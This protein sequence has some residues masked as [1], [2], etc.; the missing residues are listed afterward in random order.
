MLNLVPGLGQNFDLKGIVVN[1][2]KAINTCMR[3]L[4]LLLK[5][6]EDC[7]S[8]RVYNFCHVRN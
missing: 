6:H 5:V 1:D 2:L 3:Y 4:F 7:P 8:L